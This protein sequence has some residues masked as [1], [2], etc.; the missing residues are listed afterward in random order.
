MASSIEI[1]DTCILHGLKA[2]PSFNG[3]KVK[4]VE[5]MQK[6]GRFVLKPLDVSAPLPPVLAIRPDNLKVDGE[7][8][9]PGTHL[10]LQGLKT[11]NQ[12]NGH[13]VVVTGFLFDQD[14]YK[15][16]PE[17]PNSALPP[18]LAIKPDNLVPVPTPQGRPGMQKTQSNRSISFMSGGGFCRQGS[19]RQMENADQANQNQARQGG[20]VRHNSCP[21][22]MVKES[23]KESHRIGSR[24]QLDGLR[25]VPHF[26]GQIVIIKA[27]LAGE[28]RYQVSPVDING[29]LPPEFAVKPDNLI[30]PSSTPPTRKENAGSQ[31][32][33][34]KS[35]SQKS[36][37]LP[38]D[39]N[40]KQ[41]EP[42]RLARDSSITGLEATESKGI[43]NAIKPGDKMTIAGLQSRP[44][45]NGETVDV[46]YYVPEQG[47]YQVAPLRPS[48]D[49]PEL[50]L[51]KPS[52]LL[53]F[54]EEKVPKDIE[55]P[56]SGN[57]G[58]D[59]VT[60]DLSS[61]A[62]SR[63]VQKPLA[64]GTEVRIQRSVEPELEGMKGRVSQVFDKP[65][66]YKLEPVGL[67]AMDAFKGGEV[68][69]PHDD[70]IPDSP[71]E[72]PQGEILQPGQRGV[73]QDYSASLNGHLVKIV[74]HSSR[75]NTY[76]VEPLG[77]LAR[78]SVG[79]SAISLSTRNIMEAPT[80][81]FW[82]TVNKKGRR[83]FVPCQATVHQTASG[84]N[85]FTAYISC[86][87]GVDK[88]APMARVLL[89]EDRCN[90][91]N[92]DEVKAVLAKSASN[93]IAVD[94]KNEEARNSIGED[95]VVLKP[96]RHANTID[97]L[98]EYELIVKTERSVDVEEYGT[99]PVYK[100][101]YD[102]AAS[103]KTCD[104]SDASPTTVMS[105]A[106]T[107][108]TARRSN[109]K[110]LNKAFSVALLESE[111]MDDEALG[112]VKKE[113]SS[114]KLRSEKSDRR[115]RK[116]SSSKRLTERCRSSSSRLA[117]DYA[118]LETAIAER[119][120]EKKKLEEELEAL[121][122]TIRKEKEAAELPN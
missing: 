76:L 111:G 39:Q 77:K 16:R 86:F 24:Y 35:F 94:M 41:P 102:F 18:T 72:P 42:K 33:M 12:F 121:R 70:L 69:V 6:E 75:R 78:K 68:V 73:I 10:I 15:V 57:Q 118:E 103:H 119:E 23:S 79:A 122:E 48:G 100:L 20:M 98:V 43:A 11:Q 36:L 90:W 66:E 26:N 109:R 113:R 96:N 59:P 112:P 107:E 65:L 45:W 106:N 114:R 117:T 108:A 40:S 2:Q 93:S 85:A 71:P 28:G 34:V 62:S 63:S 7:K 58:Y 99:L 82:T 1:G 52:N 116:R 81:A 22:L 32:K 74:S 84:Q 89:G 31:I 21:R 19:I 101:I 46:R 97:A 54:G 30:S 47:R 56:V 17:D 104:K 37:V 105:S 25:S 3:H 27:Y 53:P 115:L 87:P 110:S 83:M 80:G 14:R 4:V 29:P 44:E 55:F 5:W 95:E 120:L 67:A 13:R 88:V 60:D 64:V 49:M 92:Y 50:M 38:E 9:P 8:H 91:D 61:L 51:L